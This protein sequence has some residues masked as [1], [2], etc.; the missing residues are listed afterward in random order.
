MAAASE[1][2]SPA[3]RRWAKALGW[4]LLV[5]VW[6][7]FHLWLDA[8]GPVTPVLALL[9]PGATIVWYAGR[10]ALPAHQRRAMALAVGLLAAGLLGLSIADVPDRFLDDR[11]QLWARGARSATV[12]EALA[13][14]PWWVE[15]TDARLGAE[16]AC[17]LPCA[18]PITGAD[19]RPGL[20]LCDVPDARLRLRGTLQ[21]ASGSIYAR[22]VARLAAERGVADPLCFRYAYVDQAKFE[23]MAAERADKP[24]LIVHAA[25]L[26][27]L[28]F[29]LSAPGPKRSGGSGS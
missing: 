3:R 14:P 4:A 20:W 16:R 29:V 7:D 21:P 2:K 10:R 28:Y 1:P 13:D 6:A 8:T 15:L 18:V 26:L 24:L 9:L 19:G 23:R 27:G 25:L 12:A 17:D 5:V 22:D 11:F